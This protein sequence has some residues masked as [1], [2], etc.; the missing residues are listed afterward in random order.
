MFRARWIFFLELRANFYISA[1]QY[2][3]DQS[4][5][6]E[7]NFFRKHKVSYGQKYTSKSVDCNFLL[8]FGYLLQKF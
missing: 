3:I 7:F 5:C 6:F 1:S 2:C 4:L 8:P